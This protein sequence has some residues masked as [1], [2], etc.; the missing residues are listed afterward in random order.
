[1][2][3]LNAIDSSVLKTGAEP[4]QGTVGGWEEVD[5]EEDF[6]KKNS[7]ATLDEGKRAQLE[8]ADENCR[9]KTREE[10]EKEADSEDE[11]ENDSLGNGLD[12]EDLND[13][14][15]EALIKR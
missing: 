7:L 4:N 13:P 14:E 11:S 15:M 9:A 8:R 6:Y 12:D 1:M 2:T 5:E 10:I 3:S